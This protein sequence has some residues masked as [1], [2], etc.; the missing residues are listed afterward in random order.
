[1]ASVAVAAAPADSRGLDAY[2]IS[3][4]DE[5]EVLLREKTANLRRLEAQR[6]ELNGK[7]APSVFGI[8]RAPAT[9]LLQHPRVRAARA[10]PR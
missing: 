8:P 7:G 1:M 2:Y 4:I 9:A 10:A 6:N 5:A 3:K